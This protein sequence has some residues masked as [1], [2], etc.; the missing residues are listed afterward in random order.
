MVQRKRMGFLV[1]GGY[2]LPNG[3]ILVHAL[4]WYISHSCNL[5]CSNC[6]NFNNF[7]IIGND[8]FSNQKLF[9]E[10]WA[11][12]IH[13]NDFCI[14]GGE[15]FVN[16]DL[17]NWIVGLRNLFDSKD[18][19]VVTNG[20]LLHKY[21]HKL[22]EWFDK[23][24]TIEISFHDKKHI[25]PAFAIIKEILP[26]HEHYKITEPNMIKGKAT[27]IGCEY[28]EAILIE[29]DFPA[30]II[31]YKMEFMPW[32]V[33]EIKNGIYHFHDSDREEAHDNCWHADCPYIYKGNMYKC[34]TVVGAQAIVDKY[35]VK[36]ED[37]LLYKSYNP[38]IPTSNN[39][40][41]DLLQLQKSIPQCVLCPVNNGRK[42]QLVLDKKKILP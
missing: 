4:Q 35:P 39:L 8:S 7:A 11:S 23:K 31:N 38:I 22:K 3:K 1:L 30:F 2:K 42:E 12:K 26:K 15:P 40:Q 37:K 13:V 28:K 19:K 33:K 29:N 5:T 25:E 14:I 27:H 32:G 34:G 17:H 16:N 36:K 10:Q 20:S 24:V 9:A 18:F 6:S 41:E 21:K